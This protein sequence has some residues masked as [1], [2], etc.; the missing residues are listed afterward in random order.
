MNRNLILLL[1]LLGVGIV[2]AVV[3]SVSLKRKSN[4]PTPPAPNSLCGAVKPL[5]QIIAGQDAPL[6]K[7]PWQVALRCNASCGGS[8]IYPSWVLSAAHCIP[9]CDPLKMTVILGA[10]DLK[11]NEPYKQ[12]IKAKN[13]FVHP[14]YDDI[15]IINDICL[16][17]LEK[18]ATINQYV[19]TV[20]LPSQ[21][22][23]FKGKTLYTTGFGLYDNAKPKEPS[24]KLQ[25][26]ATFAGAG[27]CPKTY[28]VPSTQ[29][30]TFNPSGGVGG[31]ATGSCRGDSGGPLVLQDGER[32]ILVG[33]VSF[34]FDVCAEK[35][36]MYTNVY[37]YM[38][39]INKTIS[40]NS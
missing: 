40:T 32:W 21:Q 28:R 33:V 36:S 1:I 12:I 11:A 24:A 23:N 37:S 22:Y 26:T 39:W 7:W 10:V 31:V 5:L 15:Q 9:G 8:L 4:E 27:V 6:G 18:P 2:I 16:I 29:I 17:Q 3:V 20:C 25:E 38:D 14:L 35:P 13:I 34:G 19:S 30:C